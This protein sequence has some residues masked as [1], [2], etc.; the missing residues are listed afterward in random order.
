M[1]EV[2]AI[3]ATM[4]LLVAVVAFGTMA[5]HPVAGEFRP[6]RALGAALAWL[7]ALIYVQAR[8]IGGETDP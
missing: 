4:Y 3:G 7:P 8:R 1:I 2:A 6:I 5:I